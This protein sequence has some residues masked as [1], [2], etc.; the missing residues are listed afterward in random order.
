MGLVLNDTVPDF[1]FVNTRRV[2]IT[3]ARWLELDLV[4]TEQF[5]Q[6]GG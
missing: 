1:T 2:F 3:V 4:L 6:Q 5:R